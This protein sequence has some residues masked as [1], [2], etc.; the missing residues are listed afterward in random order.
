MK[1]GDTDDYKIV[2]IIGK[3]DCVDYEKSDLVL[4]RNGTIKT[5]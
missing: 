5:I 2:N 1:K 3:V 4:R